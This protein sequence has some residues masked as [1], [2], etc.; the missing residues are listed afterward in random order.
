MGSLG[1]FL[2]VNFPPQSWLQRRI[3]V[4]KKRRAITLVRMMAL[5]SGVVLG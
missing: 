1:H 4:Q 3:L 2:P 5:K